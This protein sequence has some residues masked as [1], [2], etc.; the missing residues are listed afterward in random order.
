MSEPREVA[1]F[2]KVTKEQYIKDR[3]NNFNIVAQ[4]EAAAEYV[5]IKTP[6]RGT[7]HAA[8]YDFYAPFEFTV[9][10]DY[11]IL[12]PTGIFALFTDASY[13]LI[14]LPR[15][16]SG[17]KYGLRLMNTVG[18]IDADYSDAENEGHIMIKMI[19]DTPVT[20]H[21]GDRFA[22]GV[23]IPY[24]IVLDESQEDLS[25]RVGGMGS[26]GQ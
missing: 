25:S 24:G 18:L 17:F 8:G 1:K 7:K 19:S 9:T 2:Y 22:Q 26:T 3:I 6:T 12:I 20:F 4:C 11:P 15:S 13:A 21:T 23:F 5:K 14:I 16:G 10:P